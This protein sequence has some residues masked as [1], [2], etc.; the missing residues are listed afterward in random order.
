MI[1]TASALIIAK[2]LLVANAM[3]V[4]RR[5]D[6]APLRAPTAK[7]RT[8]PAMV[9]ASTAPG[10]DRFQVR[11]TADSHFAWLRTRLARERTMMSWVRTAVSPSAMPA[12][13]PRTRTSTCSGT[14]RTAPVHP[15]LRGPA[16]RRQGRTARLG[17]RPGG[18][19]RRRPA[20]VCG[21]TAARWLTRTLQERGVEL[22]ALTKGIDTRRRRGFFHSPRT[23]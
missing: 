15:H 8:A 18:G 21:S 20:L 2:A 12:Y 10:T 5:Y 22:R 17:A 13:R 9:D 3:P 1:A 7:D 19:A 16:Q 6:R 11:V 4:I 14:R 23:A